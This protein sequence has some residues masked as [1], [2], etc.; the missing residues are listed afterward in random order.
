MEIGTTR[1]RLASA[2]DGRQARQPNSE[3][4]ASITNLDTVPLLEKTVR[5][6]MDQV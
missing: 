3:R 6:R 1:V 2:V 5:T 4:R